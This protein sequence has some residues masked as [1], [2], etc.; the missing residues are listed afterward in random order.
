[1]PKKLLKMFKTA[2]KLKLRNLKEEV[3]LSKRNGS[4]SAP[5]NEL[6]K[7]L[8]STMNRLDRRNTENVGTKD[9]ANFFCGDESSKIENRRLMKLCL[10]QL[11]FEEVL[12]NDNIPADNK[13]SY[14]KCLKT[15]EW[16][17]RVSDDSLVTRVQSKY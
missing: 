13:F 17:M 16:R 8:T 3:K 12:K 11:V 7:I 2:L 14:L 4:S 5:S 6:T 1:M 10:S 15:V 9:L